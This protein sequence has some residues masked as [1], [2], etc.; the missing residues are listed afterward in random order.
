MHQWAQRDN[1]GA[2]ASRCWPDFFDKYH[3]APGSVWTQ[4]GDQK[5]PTAMECDI[6]GALSMYIL[7]QMTPQQ[8]ATFLGDVSSLDEGD[9][10]I[11]MWHDYGAY[12]LANPKYGVE[13]SVHPNRKMPVSPQMVLKP[14]LVTILRVHYDADGYRFVI[15]KG[16]VKDTPAQFNGVSGR[17]EMQ[18]PVNELMDQFVANG[19][20]SHFALVYGDYVSQLEKLAQMLDLPSTTY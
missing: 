12:S 11:T 15:T 16:T 4:L 18:Q 13:A 5:L 19:Y 3:S 7:Q 6:H 20:E 10:T 14:G 1:W 9:N 17:I 8:D 2:L